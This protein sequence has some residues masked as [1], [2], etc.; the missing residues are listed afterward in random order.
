STQYNIQFLTGTNFNENNNN[1]GDFDIQAGAG[2]TIQGAG[3]GVNRSAIESN[4]VDRI[5]HIV[6]TNPGPVTIDGVILQNGRADHAPGEKGGGILNDG[7][8]LTVTGSAFV[9]SSAGAGGAGLETNGTATTQIT[10]S[11]F[12]GG[13]MCCDGTTAGGGGIGVSSGGGGSLTVTNTEIGADAAGNQA[14]SSA[15]PPRGGG[16]SFAPTT[17]ATLNVTDSRIV[18]NSASTSSQGAEGGGVY[19][20]GPAG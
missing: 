1:K 9:G 4:G 13:N 16:I 8:N 12:R 5:F 18:D 7:G 3:T 2:L 14:Q 17:S 6:S 20:G 19:I 10:D 15:T 11:S